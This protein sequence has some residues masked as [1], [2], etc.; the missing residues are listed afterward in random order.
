[1]VDGAGTRA[2]C[3]RAGEPGMAPKLPY[4]KAH[5]SINAQAEHCHTGPKHAKLALALPS[6]QTSPT[7]PMH[8]RFLGAR[9]PDLKNTSVS[10]NARD[11][12]QRGVRRGAGSEGPP[13]PPSVRPLP[14]APPDGR[15]ALRVQHGR[16]G[17]PARLALWVEQRASARV[18]A[19]GHAGHAALD[20]RLP[21]LRVAEGAR[22]APWARPPSMGCTL[23]MECTL[24]AW[25]GTPP[26][27][28]ACSH[29]PRAPLGISYCGGIRPTYSFKCQGGRFLPVPY[30]SHGFPTVGEF[31][32]PLLLSVKMV[33]AVVSIPTIGTVGPGED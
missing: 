27:A 21:R 1:M 8:P 2:A 17:V 22:W 31:D 4:L 19:G 28:W 18:A 25:M 11:V 20:P 12:G 9:A 23:G 7:N 24:G 6:A 10:Q 33:A 30:S 15:Q 5:G 3:A 13:A 16:A 14:A 29:G 32:L 26:R